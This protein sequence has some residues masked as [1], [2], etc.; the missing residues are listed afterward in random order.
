MNQLSG[1]ILTVERD[2]G[3]A[4]IQVMV[5]DHVFTASILGP[6]ALGCLLVPGQ[7]VRVLFKESEVALAKDLTG[8]L[9]LRNRHPAR[10]EA[11]V[12]G[13]L[14]SQVIL[15]FQGERV[16]SIITTGSVQR[17]GLQAGDQVEW[18]VKTNEMAVESLNP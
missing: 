7:A 5:C 9:S 1:R 8:L 10:V 3:V 11:V 12:L 15:A 18:L 16:V 17:L 14:L 6:A 13:R 2:A 4:L